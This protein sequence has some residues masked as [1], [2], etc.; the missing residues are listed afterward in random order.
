MI[1][2]FPIIHI[3]RGIISILFMVCSLGTLYSQK[4]QQV[5]SGAIPIAIS[6]RVGTQMDS[7]DIRYYRLFYFLKDVK[8]AASYQYNFDSILFLVKRIAQPDTVIAHPIG[9]FSK[10]LS[11][12]IE[13]IERIADESVYTNISTAVLGDIAHVEDYEDRSY[14]EVRITITKRDASEIIGT[15]LLITND[16]IF[17]S[18]RKGQYDW[19]NVKS[20]LI[21]IPFGDID[22]IEGTNVRHFGGNKQLI[23]N[24]L[25]SYYNADKSTSYFV[26]W[27]QR[28][29]PTEIRQLVNSKEYK[30]SEY[31]DSL[32]IES[33]RRSKPSQNNFRVGIGLGFQLS[34]LFNLHVRDWNNQ[35]FGEVNSVGNSLQFPTELILDYTVLKDRTEDK[36]SI[37]AHVT[38]LTNFI[39]TAANSWIGGKAGLK[40]EYVFNPIDRIFTTGK[41]YGFFIGVDYFG[42]MYS[43]N[44]KRVQGSRELPLDDNE[45][46]VSINA[47][48]LLLIAGISSKYQFSDKWSL[49]FQLSANYP[50]N[51]Y[52]DGVQKLTWGIYGR[53]FYKSIN[54]TVQDYAVTIGATLSYSI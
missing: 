41:Q 37:S 48:A 34:N 49:D 5:P 4:F 54:L 33:L 24:T 18:Q 25:E 38:C 10:Y 51:R 22:K 35:G 27:T 46:P 1:S 43:G 44:A 3:R 40:G 30:E 28:P 15:I 23:V 8:S 32:P 7:I 13:N 11:Y 52:V 20:E 9:L 21:R 47:S 12:Y 31:K 39:P 16:A 50:L 6:P 17:I 36:W 14:E 19:K 2:I 29:L 53:N 26:T 45:Q 42:A